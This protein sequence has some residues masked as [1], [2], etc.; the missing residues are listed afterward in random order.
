MS[1]TRWKFSTNYSLP[2]HGLAVLDVAI[3]DGRYIV[4]MDVRYLRDR[5]RHRIGPRP[6]H[7]IECS[8]AVSP[9]CAISSA[10]DCVAI[11]GCHGS[12]YVNILITHDTAQGKLWDEFFKAVS[13]SGDE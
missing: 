1:P 5:V 9:H 11:V 4:T 2:I 6:G 8:D 12:L 3:S 10:G 7:E 13:F